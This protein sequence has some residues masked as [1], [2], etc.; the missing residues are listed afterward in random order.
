MKLERYFR[1][2]QGFTILELMTVVAIAGILMAVGVPSYNN[3]VKNNCLTTKANSLVSSL[4]FARSE[5]AKRNA[6]VSIDA[7]NS[8]DNTNE[9]GTG[10]T[11]KDNIG[12]T[13]RTVQLQCDLTTVDETS[14][15]TSFTYGG[16]GFIVNGGTLDL[17]D[18]RTGETGRQITISVTGRPAVANLT[19]T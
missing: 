8:G 19:C 6:S 3:M 1:S 9:W 13:I 12:N 10:W 11:I 18:D 7:S 16:D 4:Q 2:Q 15:S 14:D 17:C 5:A